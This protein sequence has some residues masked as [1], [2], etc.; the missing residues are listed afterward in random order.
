MEPGTLTSARTARARSRELTAPWVAWDAWRATHGGPAGIAARQAA[1]LEAL[2]QHARQASRFY[3]EHY[4]TVPPGPIDP[5]AFYRLPPVTKPELMARFD[6]W[7]TDPSVTRAD[8]EQFIADLDNLGRDFLDQYVI[9]TTSGSTGVPALLVE[10]RRAVA[11]MTGLSY[12]RA[13]SALSSRLL[14]RM[15]TRA[16]R[17]AAVFASGGHFLSTTIFERRLR[18]APFRQRTTRFFSVLDPLP[19]LIAQLNA[20]QPAMLGTYASALTALT[21]EQEAGRLRISP[22]VIT[23]G[24]ELLTPAVQHRAEEAFGCL[25]NQTYGA[26]EAIPLALPCRYGRLHLNSDWFVVEPID[27]EGRPVPP[28]ARSDGLLVTNLANYVQPVIRYQLGDSVVITDQRCACRS[29]LATILVEGRTD[30]ILRIPR[31]EGGEVIVLPMAVAT[32]VEE[33]RGV[34]RYQVLQTATDVI[35]V[36][37]DHDPGMDRAEVWQRVSAGL[38]DLLRAH[39]CDGVSLRL[40]AEPPQVNPRSGKLR[41]VLRS[42]PPAAEDV[43]DRRSDLV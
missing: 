7:V 39:G 19:K 27:A 30:E 26:S 21:A 14:P 18:L 40:A 9:F 23:T 33:T 31:A 2:V 3:A 38:A 6:D 16:P 37:L 34:R 24:G 20:F 11:V 42:V 8:V 41:H 22:L 36:R 10:D 25:V 15:L 35:T 4:R 32:V 13:L 5:E 1:R 12:V 17:Q 43:A 29:P 28:G